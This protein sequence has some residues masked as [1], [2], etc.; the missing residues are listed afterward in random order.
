MTPTI[1]ARV[2]TGRTGL[3][4]PPSLNHVALTVADLD[5]A[6]SWYASVF[7]FEVLA[8]PVE[9]E[10]GATDEGSSLPDVFGKRFRK[11]RMCW[12]AT[13]GATGFELFEFVDPRTEERPS[14]EYWKTGLMHFAVT[15]GDVEEVANRIDASGGRRVSKVWPWYEGHEFTYCQDP[16]GN[17]V[18][19]NSLSFERV[20][21]NREIKA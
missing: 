1:A 16:W 21:A 20:N 9:F 11:L 10:I 15:V 7:G 6:V 2:D 17:I 3:T 19:L 5:A 13:G 8:G 14:F 12:M 4:Y 18:E